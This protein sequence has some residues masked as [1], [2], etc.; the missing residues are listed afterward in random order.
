MTTFADDRGSG[1]GESESELIVP[2]SRLVV[3]SEGQGRWY[4]AHTRSR[5]EKILAEEM[6]RMRIFSYLPLTERVTRSAVTRRVSKSVVPVFPGY[7]FFLANE[8]QR[9]LALRTNRIAQIL[10][11]P[12][13]AQLV[14]EL[15]QVH[16]LLAQTSA[17]S[18]T[19]RLEEGDWVRIIRGPIQGLEGVVTRGSDR[20]RLHL[21]VTTLG[22][23]VHVEINSEDVEKIDPPQY[24][25]VLGRTGSRR[26]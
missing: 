18:V 5:N 26:R 24:A 14:A 12:D 6:G 22:Q 20:W 9:Y 11:V 21:N 2:E 13:Q 7:V 23:S 8:E 17:F 10:N 4:V 3:P 19:T 15:R 16:H 1:C 25:V